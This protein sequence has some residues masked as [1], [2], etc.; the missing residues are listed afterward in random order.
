M[1]SWVSPLTEL[2]PL[3]V[4]IPRSL[5]SLASSSWYMAKLMLNFRPL[6]PLSSI[7]S[8]KV[9]LRRRCRSCSSSS[10]FFTSTTRSMMCSWRFL[11]L[12]FQ[13]SKFC[14]YRKGTMI[15]VSFWLLKKKANLILLSEYIFL[16]N[17]VESYRLPIFGIIADFLLYFLHLLNFL[18]LFL[19]CAIQ[20]TRSDFDELKRIGRLLR[21]RFQRRF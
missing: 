8:E 10:S 15:I 12:L 6:L 14:T 20:R 18:Q 5:R 2:F 17:S 1:S 16:E 7:I 21:R 4:P 19:S 11:R 3:L 13:L 9:L